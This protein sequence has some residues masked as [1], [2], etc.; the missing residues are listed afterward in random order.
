VLLC[1]RR[2]EK[3]YQ[4]KLIDLNSEDWWAAKTRYPPYR[5]FTPISED[6]WAGGQQKHATHPTEI[7]L[8]NLG[9]LNCPMPGTIYCRPL[10]ID[11]L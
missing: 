6:W 1:V 3:K 9:N 4:A 2:K 5:N 8:S 7:F 10:Q 11:D